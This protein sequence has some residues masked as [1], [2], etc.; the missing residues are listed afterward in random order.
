[1]R[2][3]WRERVQALAPQ[4]KQERARAAG[5]SRD[6]LARVMKRNSDG[7]VVGQ[8]REGDDLIPIVARSV[9]S[10]RLRAATSLDELQITPK[11][12]THSIP[13][14]QVID[15]I[16]VPMGSPDHLAKKSSATL[17]DCGLAVLPWVIRQRSSILMVRCR[18]HA[19]SD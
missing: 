7:V 11:L 1:M 10:Q 13:V 2:V 4:D 15:G 16:E 8:Y 18:S 14:S 6:D 17:F 5:V 3:N 9:E 19:S 12:S